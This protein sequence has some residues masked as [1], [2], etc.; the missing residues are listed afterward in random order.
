MNCKKVYLHICESLD[1]DL[2]SPR[3]REIRNHL[4]D[5]PNCRAYLDSIKK[6]ITLYRMEPAPHVPASVHNR[7]IKTIDLSWKKGTRG[8]VTPKQ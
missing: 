5:C 6:T 1:E 8:K 4:D 7:L 3:C 2:N